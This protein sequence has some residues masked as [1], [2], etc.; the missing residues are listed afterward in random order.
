MVGWRCPAGTDPASGSEPLC[1]SSRLHPATS[2]AAAALMTIRL[3]RKGEDI[4]H[5]SRRRL[6]GQILDGVGKAERRRRISR[7]ELVFHDSAGPSADSGNHGDVLAAVGAAVAD[8]LAD[9]SAAGLEPPDELA[10]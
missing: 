8:R 5:A 1:R 2:R 7:I 3:S 9:D 4:E 6:V 10:G